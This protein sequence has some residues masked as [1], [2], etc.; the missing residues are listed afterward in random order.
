MMVLI[1]ELPMLVE[2]KTKQMFFGQLLPVSSTELPMLVERKSKQTLF[3]VKLN[4]SI[5]RIL[6]IK[7]FPKIFYVVTYIGSI[8]GQHCL[9][10]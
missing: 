6:H 3:I 8:Y 4:G 2:Q 10:L 7:K 5:C 9:V 1:T